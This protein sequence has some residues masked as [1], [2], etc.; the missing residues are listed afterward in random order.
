MEERLDGGTGLL[1]LPRDDNIGIF[2]LFVSKKATK[3]LCQLTNK[4]TC[5]YKMRGLRA[6]LIKSPVGWLQAK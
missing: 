5:H 1:E 6:S 2:F 4:S 3:Q